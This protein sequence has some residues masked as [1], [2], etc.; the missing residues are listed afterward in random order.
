MEQLLAYRFFVMFMQGFKHTDYFE[1]I[2]YECVLYA[3]LIG[4]TALTE[5]EQGDNCSQED[6]ILFYSLCSR[7]DHTEEE[8]LTLKS[9]ICDE[10][11]YEMD[12]LLKLVS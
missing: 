7:T 8:K 11:Y 6:R 4:Y 10:G 3:A 12:K 2:V 1:I 9:E 5:I